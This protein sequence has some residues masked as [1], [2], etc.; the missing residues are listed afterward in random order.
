MTADHRFQH[1][2]TLRSALATLVLP[3]Q[4]VLDAPA[5][6]IVAAGEHMAF[7]QT[8]IERNAA[9]GEENLKLQALLLRH[10]ALE[11]ENRR[12]RALLDSS[13]QLREATVVAELLS[14]DL[15]PFRQQIVINRGTR[16]G[17][18][19]G[20]PILDTEGVVGQIIEA[21][22]FHSI[23]LL[24]SDPSH[25]LPVQVQRTGLRTLV[26]GTGKPDELALPF[27]SPN[28]DIEVGDLLTTSG[29]G[30][31]FPPDYPVAVVSH[32]EQP[33]GAPFA[34][35]KVRPLAR[36]DRGREVLLLQPTP[37]ALPEI[38][39]QPADG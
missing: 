11:L 7:R 2:Q 37:E 12:L 17:A 27:A 10:E 1:T 28:E 3:L 6:L 4:L 24:I 9:L 26:V 13:K 16:H 36:L 34:I 39:E 25:T 35:I 20:Q 32:I 38:A 5:R 8:L 22:P 30:G 15:D 29:L 21:Y 23:A 14:I 33:A 19:R 31:R 18:F